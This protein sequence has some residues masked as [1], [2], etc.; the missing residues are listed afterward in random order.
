MSG[1]VIL[2]G[3]FEGTV[4]Q[5]LDMRTAQELLECHRLGR[6]H[7]SPAN[8]VIARVRELRRLAV[9]PRAGRAPDSFATRRRAL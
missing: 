2:E 5:F 1:T 9:S 7:P 3:K 8:A 6:Q 4:V